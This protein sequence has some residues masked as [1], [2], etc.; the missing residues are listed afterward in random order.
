MEE[1]GKGSSPT[2][3]TN[4]SWGG[5]DSSWGPFFPYSPSSGLGE[6][7]SPARH[8]LLPRAQGRRTQELQACITWLM[9]TEGMEAA[10]T[11]EWLGELGSDLQG[12]MQSCCFFRRA[13]TFWATGEKNE[14]GSRGGEREA[15]HSSAGPSG[16]RTPRGVPGPDPSG[17]QQ[18]GRVCGFS[19]KRSCSTCL[20]IRA[21]ECKT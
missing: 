17:D 3:P 15:C 20:P 8:A 21:S 1:D 10:E 16:E 12:P 4:G 19:T 18:E 6:P 14:K 5:T 11:E 2:R 7:S 9:C 13:T